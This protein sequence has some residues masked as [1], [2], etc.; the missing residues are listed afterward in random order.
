MIFCKIF[1]SNFILITLATT[2]MN[3]VAKADSIVISGSSKKQVSLSG[4]DNLILS[5]NAEIDYNKKAISISNFSN[6][7][8]K[9]EPGSSVLSVDDSIHGKYNTKNSGTISII[10]NGTFESTGGGQSIDLDD[11]SNSSKTTI[12]NGATGK[13]IADDAD[14]IRPGSNATIL[15]AGLIYA[16]GAVGNS[17]DAVDFQSYSG[18]VINQANGIIS[19]ARH[20]VTTDGNINVLNELNGTIIGRNG[21]G[22]GSDGTGTVVNYGSITGAYDGSGTGDG[23]GVD[24][25]G[26]ASISNYGT[27][28]ATG[29]GGSKADGRLNGAEGLA[30]S[31]GGIVY[32]GVH[33]VITSVYSGITACCTYNSNYTITNY[34]NIHGNDHGIGLSGASNTQNYGTISGD[35]GIVVDANYGDKTVA[36]ID[37]HGSINGLYNAIYISPDATLNLTV[38]DGSTITGSIAND[39]F[40]NISTNDNYYLSASIV[41]I[42]S[43]E[44]SGSGSIH[45][46]A[47]NTYSG[48]T[49]INGLTV[50]GNTLS[51]GTGNIVNDAALIVAQ[52]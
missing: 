40:L 18:T 16:A 50:Y 49:I 28:S 19:G 51:F 34:G 32:N 39:G 45:L 8:I 42:G 47:Q 15:N 23:D 22:V 44:L 36:N 46:L 30:L 3:C 33:G 10:N 27:I 11:V 38:H 26:Y 13:L 25:D 52:D 2:S 7:S 6:I 5:G 12:Q 21:S 43:L 20:G 41:N 29:A 9:T 4:N 14:G 37:N 1:K 48:D 35:N 31:G 17:H 24:I